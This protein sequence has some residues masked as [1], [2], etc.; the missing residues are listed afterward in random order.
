MGFAL[1]ERPR[2][3]AVE[4]GH[5]GYR[6]LGLG[7]FTLIFRGPSLEEPVRVLQLDAK[8]QLK[9]A[10]GFPETGMGRQDHQRVASCHL[11]DAQ[12]RGMHPAKKYEIH[13]MKHTRLS[14][15]RH[16]QAL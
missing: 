11:R 9:F 12:R 10:P 5:H 2:H 14:Q 13:N 7:V 16:G 4:H 6:E 3:V 1:H 8:F 15:R